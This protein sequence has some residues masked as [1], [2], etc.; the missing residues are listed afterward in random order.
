MTVFLTPEQQ[1][2]FAGTYFPPDDALRAARASATLL[3]A[4]RRALG[5]DRATRRA[6]QATA[7]SQRLARAPAAAPGGGAGEPPSSRDRAAAQL[8]A[9]FDARYG[10][11]GGAPKFPHAAAL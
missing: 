6:T 1:P 3:E 8:A 2:F 5:R 11:F 9:D 4:H 10:G 7:S